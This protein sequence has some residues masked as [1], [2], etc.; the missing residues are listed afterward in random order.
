MLLTALNAI[1]PI[2]GRYRSKTKSLSAYFSEEALIKYR[3]QI[4]I[5]YFIGLCELPLPQLIDFNPSLF[6]ELRSI[7]LHFTS[8]DALQIKEIESTTNHDVK[9]VEYFIKKEFDKLELQDY[10]EFIHFGLTSQDI[11]N[12]AIPLSVKNAISEVYLPNLNLVIEH[13]EGMV[14]E[15]KDIPLLA[16]THGQPASP[17]RLGKE[18]DVFVQRLKIQRVMLEKVPNGAKFSG[19]TGNFN[20]HKVAY[21]DID[22]KAFGTHFVEKTLGLN[23]SFPTTQIEHYDSFATLC[24]N[25]KRINTILIDLN[26][27][28]WQY[29]SMDYFKQQIKEGEVGS[30]AMPH[31]V[32]PI[33]F[34][35]SE[36]NLGMA[37]A[38]FEFLSAKLPISRLQRDLTDSTVLRNIGVPF[39]HTI[40]G[41]QSTFKGLGKLLVNTTKIEDD[42]NANWAVVAEAVQTILRKEGYPNPYEALKELTRTNT[43]INRDAIQQFIA[44]LDVDESLKAKLKTITP[45]N[46]TGI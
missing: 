13:L 22:W 31:K 44:G 36:G 26:R 21:P 27:D 18:F 6:E 16:R 41:L 45:F 32:N 17:T 7:Y 40:I 1:S 5:E 25:M 38:I 3:V 46:Y 14:I 9:A 43:I 11:N 24:D 39:G 37:N 15:F 10:K 2:D 4:E 23:Y 20:A 30:S 33:D 12:T 19:A 29:I 34:E 28:L 35:N 42:L 8:D